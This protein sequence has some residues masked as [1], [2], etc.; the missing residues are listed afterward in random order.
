MSMSIL[1]RHGH[2][3]IADWFSFKLKVDAA[4]ANSAKQKQLIYQAVNYLYRCEYLVY[5]RAQMIADTARWDIDCID[6]FLARIERAGS[7]PGEDGLC[8]LDATTP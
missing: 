4:P 7:A 3:D 5:R 2:L 8:C 1:I 6:Q